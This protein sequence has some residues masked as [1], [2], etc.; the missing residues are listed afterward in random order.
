[1]TTKS[2]RKYAAPRT[3]EQ[4][5]SLL[6]EINAARQK[7]ISSREIAASHGVSLTGLF[8]VLKMLRDAGHEVTD[9][10]CENLS[11]RLGNDWDALMPLVRAEMREGLS[12]REIAAK[13]GVTFY[14][15]ENAIARHT[16]AAER[17]AWRVARTQ[18]RK[19]VQA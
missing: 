11:G 13:I 15:L 8:R 2:K 4:W 3:L 1:M 16:I 6:P 7:A 9:A 5:A 18:R 10:V 19:S 12:A 17:T 14:A